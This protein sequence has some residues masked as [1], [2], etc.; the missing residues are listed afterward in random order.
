[1]PARDNR[2]DE[3]LIR[4]KE[5][6]PHA[7]RDEIRIR[8]HERSGSER[9]D[10]RDEVRIRR[11]ER[12]HSHRDA[13]DDF[14]EEV[15]VRRRHSLPPED[16]EEDE[17]IRPRRLVEDDE[18][19]EILVHRGR[20][21]HNKKP[22]ASGGGRDEIYIRDEPGR[23]KVEFRHTHGPP[24]VKSSQSRQGSVEREDIIRLSEHKGRAGRSRLEK[25]LSRQSE[26]ASSSESL[27]EPPSVIRK[28]PIVQEVITHHRHIESK[29]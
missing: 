16:E 13:E 20:R 29:L 9:D 1:V 12:L 18:R 17:V 28:P 26:A 8:H 24:S 14:L 25:E 2:G 21:D 11:K 5:R 7:D 15:R 10:D 23:E 6:P 22:L 4:H 19:E 27:P 3:I